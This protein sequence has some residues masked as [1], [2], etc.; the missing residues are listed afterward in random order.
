MFKTVPEVNNAEEWI[1]GDAQEAKAKARGKHPPVFGDKMRLEIAEM[2]RIVENLQVRWSCVCCNRHQYVEYRWF[3]V[4]VYWSRHRH[5]QWKHC[6]ENYQCRCYWC[7]WTF[8]V[9]RSFCW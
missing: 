9:Q 3:H 2:E 6:G 1:T 7:E 8:D 4:I 5:I